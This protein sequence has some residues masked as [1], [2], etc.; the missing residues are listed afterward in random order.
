VNPG[1]SIYTR[2]TSRLDAAINYTPFK[3]VTFSVEAT[4]LLHD[5][6]ASYFGAYDALPVGVR[7]QART[8]QTSARFRF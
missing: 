7:V 8:I 2:S 3:F 1:Y 4:N 5:N 6:A